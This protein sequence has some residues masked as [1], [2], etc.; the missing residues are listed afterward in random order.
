[1]KHFLKNKT[2]RQ[3]EV[4][5]KVKKESKLIDKS[6]VIISGGSTHFLLLKCQ[7]QNDL[8][9]EAFSCLICY[10]KIYFFR[11]SVKQN[12]SLVK[13]LPVTAFECFISD[14][15]CYENIRYK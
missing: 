13:Y 5:S 9:I 3:K 1:M 11:L 2:R 10:F 4:R 6:T 7:V 15:N 8:K 12:D 14:K